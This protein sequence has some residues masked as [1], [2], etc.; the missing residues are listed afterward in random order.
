MRAD[1]GHPVDLARFITINCDLLQATPN[2]RAF[3]S[4]QFLGRASLPASEIIDILARDIQILLREIWRRPNADT[5]W[6]VELG[7]GVIT[8]TN[9]L[10]NEHARDSAM[11]HPVARISGD[12]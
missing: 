11:C 7:P 9:E 1:R 5:R 2:H 4:L 8:P 10:G 3:T 12:N 6:I